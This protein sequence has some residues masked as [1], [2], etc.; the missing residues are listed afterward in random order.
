MHKLWLLLDKRPPLRERLRMLKIKIKP[1]LYIKI[2][3][4]WDLCY[5]NCQFIGSGE[6]NNPW[7]SLF[8][9]MLD[10]PVLDHARRYLQCKKETEDAG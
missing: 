10:S 3:E 2:V 1:D 9:K 6:E 5:N 7:C 8:D 4:D